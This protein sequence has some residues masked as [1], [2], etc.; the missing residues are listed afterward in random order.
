M[1]EGFR[2]LHNLSQFGPTHTRE[3]L[4]RRTSN[5]YVYRS[6]GGVGARQNL[7]DEIMRINL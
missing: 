5:Q 3:C 7:A 1:E 6:R 4:T 2:V